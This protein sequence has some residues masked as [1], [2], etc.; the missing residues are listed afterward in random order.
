MSEAAIR[1][2]LRF[3]GAFTKE[4]R[5]ASGLTV[6]ATV[7]DE[8][9]N[10]VLANQEATEISTSGLY[11]YV[12]PASLNDAPGV[13]SLVFSTD[14]TTVDMMDVPAAIVVRGNDTSP[15]GSLPVVSAVALTKA[16]I[17]SFVTEFASSENA[18]PNRRIY[19]MLVSQALKD[20][21]EQTLLYKQTWTNADGGALTITGNE[22][23][24]GIDCIKI[25]RVEWEGSDKPL[26]RKSAAEM[27][28]DYPGWRTGNG[29]P[30]FYV[31]ADTRTILLS[32]APTG[33]VTGKL[34][35]RGSGY[36]P[37]LVEDEGAQNPLVFVPAG[38]QI[39]VAY[40]VIAHL[41]VTAPALINESAAA[42]SA[43]QAEAQRRLAVR[44][45]YLLMYRECLETIL[46]KVDRRVNEEFTF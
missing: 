6:T 13:W 21:S 39:M 5:L 27:D 35:I 11:R 8:S 12:L 9:D 41:P 7:Y 4:K 29:R 43:A 2:Q 3:I 31:V 15:A 20:I 32:P 36:L 37:E 18:K 1:E 45:K 23:N 19:E 34:T 22:V 10:V 42:V 14:D 28:N 33:D 25:D 40:Y 26:V 24:L 17:V 30:I 16:D 44:E 46:S 38:S